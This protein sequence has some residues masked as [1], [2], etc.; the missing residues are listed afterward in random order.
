MRKF[1]GMNLQ[2]VSLRNILFVKD[3]VICGEL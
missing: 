2:V 3:M 1:K